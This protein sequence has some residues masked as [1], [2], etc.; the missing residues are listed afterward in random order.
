MVM[1]LSTPE[2][3]RERDLVMKDVGQKK[4][5]L[6]EEG[7]ESEIDSVLRPEPFLATV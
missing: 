2:R 3:K 6:T 1:D 5:A 4:K 7:E